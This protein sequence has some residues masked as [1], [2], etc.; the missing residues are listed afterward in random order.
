[1]LV[2]MLSAV[3][4]EGVVLYAAVAQRIAY[5]FADIFTWVVGKALS[6]VN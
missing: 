6:K 3:I 4:P 5:I 1:V 2:L